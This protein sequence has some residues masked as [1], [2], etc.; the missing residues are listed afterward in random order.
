MSIRAISLSVLVCDG[1]AT[2]RNGSEGQNALEL[3]GE[4][5]GEGWRFPN[6]VNA[7]G[8]PVARVHDDVCP[9]CVEDWKPRG[10]VRHTPKSWREAG[11]PG[12]K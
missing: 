11:R 2:T 8:A 7:T 12:V 1:C 6:K 3:R 9:Q 4:A 5:Y 10:Y